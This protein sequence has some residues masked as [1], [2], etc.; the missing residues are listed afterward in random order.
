M[1]SPD[2]CFIK[3]SAMWIEAT[4]VKFGL[5]GFGTNAFETLPTNIIQMIPGKTAQTTKDGNCLFSTFSYLFTSSQQS[6]NYIRNI[7]CDQLNKFRLPRI[8]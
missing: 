5:Y 7:I 3:P 8:N 1:V 6:S 2:H 4:C